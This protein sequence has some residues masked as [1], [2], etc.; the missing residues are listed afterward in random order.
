MQ[1]ETN[2]FVRVEQGQYTMLLQQEMPETTEGAVYFSLPGQDDY[3]YEY[4]G[5]LDE[6]LDAL[7]EIYESTGT[8]VQALSNEAAI[9]VEQLWN[10]FDLTGEQELEGENEYNFQ[11]EGNTLLILPK[12]NLGEVV[13]I[14]RNGQV[15]STFESERF[16]HLMERFTIAYE[17]IQL[18]QSQN[19]KNQECERG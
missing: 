18:V 8:G 5:D 2:E 15:E 19:K 9:V 10:Y 16:E 17:Q 14:D 1:E 13:E 3:L 4:E 11:V 7:P 12:D 6:T